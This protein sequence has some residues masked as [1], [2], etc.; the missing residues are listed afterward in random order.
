[1]LERK[2]KGILASSN[3]AIQAATHCGIISGQSCLTWRVTA[4]PLCPQV[5][6]QGAHRCPRQCYFHKD[7][8]SISCSLGTPASTMPLPSGWRKGSGHAG[9]SSPTHQAPPLL[10]L[11]LQPQ[12][13][14]SPHLTTL[15]FCL[16]CIYTNPPGA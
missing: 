4:G 3:E 16:T 2:K 7:V 8:S 6:T 1:M 12:A 11:L 14:F 10:D 5:V 13:F 15:S 9:L